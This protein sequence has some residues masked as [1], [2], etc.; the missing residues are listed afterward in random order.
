MYEKQFA[1]KPQQIPP[2]GTRVKDDLQ[3]IGFKRNVIL[4]L[5]VSTKTPWILNR[6]VVDFS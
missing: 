6:P 4:P 1:K 2:L 3:Y 5:V